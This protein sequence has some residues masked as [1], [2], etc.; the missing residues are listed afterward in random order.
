[1]QDLRKQVVVKVIRLKQNG[2]THPVVLR[3][4]VFTPN[5]KSLESEQIQAIV[6]AAFTECSFDLFG[7]VIMNMFLWVSISVFTCRYRTYYSFVP[8]HH[9]WATFDNVLLFFVVMPWLINLGKLL[10]GVQGHRVTF[11]R[12]ENYW[13]RRNRLLVW[14]LQTVVQLVVIV[15]LWR[16]GR[17]VWF[18][19]VASI[20]LASCGALLWIQMLFLASPFT[21]IGT[22]FLPIVSAWG[23]MASFLLVSAFLLLASAQASYALTEMPLATIAIDTYLMGFI[24]E[25]Q[26]QLFVAKTLDLDANPD[27]LSGLDSTEVPRIG[28][29]FF[30]LMVSSFILMVSMA[31][32]F[33]QVMGDAYNRNKEMV[34]IQLTRARAEESLITML[35]MA[36]A[37]SLLPR[38]CCHLGPRD[39]R[40][41]VWFTR[42]EQ[43]A[44]RERTLQEL[45]AKIDHI[46]RLMT[47]TAS[48]KT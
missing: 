11:G 30:I 24:G 32:I 31:N 9:H 21:P 19:S 45:A 35:W 47:E 39:R 22:R 29:G 8:P 2:L 42:G 48:A 5:D 28:F 15:Q 3:G 37:A 10:F 41:F 38:R 25:I 36:G 16:E 7:E 34:Q 6:S 14:W 40:E 4:L 20:S 26:P 23:D 17:S 1:M 44:P 33:I 27:T 18:R 12:L 46:D 43:R 13:L